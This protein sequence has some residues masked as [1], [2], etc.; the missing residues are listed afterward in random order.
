MASAVMA[1]W[2]PDHCA[3]GPAELR[4]HRLAFLR[5][6]IRWGAGA[7]DIL[8]APG[9]SVW[10][11]LW[12][13]GGTMEGIDVKEGRGFAYRRREVQVLLDGEPRAAVAY[14]VI[15]KKPAH[16]PPAVEYMALLLAGARE[17]GLPEDY[18]ERLEAI[19]T[20]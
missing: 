17:H 7:A 11:V 6:S 10:G 15:H 3:L 20:A 8:P 4:D 5:R 18:V 1:E 19:G 9:E 14:D 16:V 13:L 2:A 12:E